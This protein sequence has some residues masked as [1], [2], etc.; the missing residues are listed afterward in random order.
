MWKDFDANF[1]ADTSG[2]IRIIEDA[3]SV[4]QSLTNCIGIMKK[5]NFFDADFGI[6]I[7]YANG[8]RLDGYMT[9]AIENEIRTAIENYEPRVKV[10]KIIV[11]VKEPKLKVDVNYSL[12]TDNRTTLSISFLLSRTL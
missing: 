10:N 3:E 6:D 11:S 5:Q 8:K 7:E 1:T 9:A 2:D 4:E 12:I